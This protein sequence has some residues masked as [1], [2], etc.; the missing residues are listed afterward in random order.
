MGGNSEMLNL[1]AK[2]A[3]DGLHSL[4]HFALFP[5]KEPIHGLLDRRS[6]HEDNVV[7]QM[8]PYTF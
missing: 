7:K 3:N 1:R 5:V 4:P 2:R 8:V 6:L